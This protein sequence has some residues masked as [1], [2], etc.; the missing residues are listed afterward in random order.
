M[1]AA[2]QQCFDH[3]TLILV[4]HF[5]FAQ[6]GAAQQQCFDLLPSFERHSFMRRRC[7]HVRYFGSAQHGA[8][9]HP[10]FDLLTLTLALLISNLTLVDQK[11]RIYMLLFP[12]LHGSLF[13]LAVAPFSGA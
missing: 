1:H 9:Q 6:H 8:A 10:C 5:G 12:W 3:L 2:Q 4:L 13:L 7:I 11:T